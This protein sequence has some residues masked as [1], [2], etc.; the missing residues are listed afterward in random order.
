MIP[1][2]LI[3]LWLSVLA[4]LPAH[5]S[6]SVAFSGLSPVLFFHSQCLWLGEFSFP[7]SPDPLGVAYFQL[8]D[9]EPSF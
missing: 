3:L 8:L 7:N 1:L 9:L 5:G 2:K 4:G 6:S